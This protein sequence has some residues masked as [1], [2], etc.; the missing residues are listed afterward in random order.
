MKGII[1]SRVSTEEQDYE[2]QTKDLLEYAHRNNIELICEPLEEKESG[3]N[4]ERT[5][6][7]ELLKFTKADVDI[8]LVWELTRLSRK[9]IKLQQTVQDFIN[10]GIRIFAYKDGFTTHNTDGSINEMAKM[11]LAL[12]ATIAE[13]EAK[14][15]KLRTMAGRTYSIVTKG[16]SYTTKKLYG[17]DI[18]NGMLKINLNEAT[19]IKHIF[20]MCTEGLSFRR[21]SIYLN[22]IDNSRNWTCGLLANLFRNPTYKGKRMW[23]KTEIKTPAIVSETLWEMAQNAI[24]QRTKNRSKGIEKHKI[25]YFLKG[26]L[27]CSRCGRKYTYSNNIY[28]CI[29]NVNK[30][31]ERCGSTTI[32]TP[33]LDAVV[34]S[35]VQEIFKDVILNISYVKQKKEN[36]DKLTKLANDATILTKNIKKAINMSKKQMEFALNIKD[37]NLELY[38]LFLTKIT[39]LLKEEKNIRTELKFV[40]NTIKELNDKMQNIG[41][42][43]TYTILNESDKKAFIHK[44]V[45]NIIVYGGRSRKVLQIFF[46]QNQMYDIIYFKKKWYGFHNANYVEY[47]DLK[48]TYNKGNEILI[49]VTDNKNNIFGK[50]IKKSCTFDEF[51]NKLKQK[52]LLTPISIKH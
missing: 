32:A 21:I 44:I 5:K 1:Y 52:K 6:F 49:K 26:L 38:E 31:Y 33:Q 39:D 47:I 2:R 16:R 17:Y 19:V 22:S 25:N 18:K 29:S 30:F 45:K 51:I 12:T 27:I 35:V 34:W 20:E 24:S 48:S 46:L 50:R 42:F 13:S 14:T 36:E 15:L 23:G 9:S 7:N 40:L 43:N 4:D 41:R 28:K 8:I 3:F 11:V 10:K 37:D